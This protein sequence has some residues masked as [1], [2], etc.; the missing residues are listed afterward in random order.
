MPAKTLYRNNVQDAAARI[1]SANRARLERQGVFAVNIVGGAG[2]GKTTLIEATLRRL[3]PVTR[4]AVITADPNS[5]GDAERLRGLAVQCA[6]IDTGPGRCLKANQIHDAL[7]QLKLGAL[8][9]LLIENVSS[10]IGPPENDLG[11]S[12]RVAVF[13]V[14]AGDDKLS[15]YADV[16]RWA[17]VLVLNK[18]D[19][20]AS[21]EF[22]L[23]AFRQRLRRVKPDI[24]CFELSAL[25]GEGIDAWVSWLR[26]ESHHP[27]E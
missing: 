2:C 11:E 27:V 19:L 8:D 20:L 26:W 9:L 16:V 25:N 5:R 4:T 17:D 15:K 13:S 7:N 12:K 21:F 22:D 6:H 10:L 3:T 24:A 23:H 18:S 14:A 1:A